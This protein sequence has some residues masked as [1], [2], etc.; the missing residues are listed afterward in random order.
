M[1]GPDCEHYA[2]PP[3]LEQVKGALSDAAAART[4]WQS[5]TIGVHTSGA[6][7]EDVR[8]VALL[9]GP[10]HPDK[11]LRETGVACTGRDRLQGRGKVKEIIEEPGLEGAKPADTPVIVSQSGKIEQSGA[12][13]SDG[14]GKDVEVSMREAGGS[15][16]WRQYLARRIE[17]T[18]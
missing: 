12:N 18:C 3:A 4:S 16:A 6:S 15:R 10:R 2:P 11:M 9:L 1:D 14:D 8:R 13:Q 17:I 7:P 5:L